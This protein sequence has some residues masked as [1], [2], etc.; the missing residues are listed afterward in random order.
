MSGITGSL[1]AML[2]IL[3]MA[4]LMAP[5]LSAAVGYAIP[6]TLSFLIYWFLLQVFPLGVVGLFIAAVGKEPLLV[7][8]DILSNKIRIHSGSLIK[9]FDVSEKELS[10]PSFK[11]RIEIAGKMMRTSA[12][13]YRVLQE[14]HVYT[15]YSTFFSKNLLSIEA[16]SHPS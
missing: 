16:L 11:P 15:G 2:L 14:G 12:V 7:V 9:P 8:L 3:I 5:V 6:N 4:I 10:Q 1:L 13:V